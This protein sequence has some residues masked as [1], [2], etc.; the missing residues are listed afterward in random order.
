LLGW[1]AIWKFGVG[2]PI[3]HNWTDPIPYIYNNVFSVEYKDPIQALSKPGSEI[4]I[5]ILLQLFEAKPARGNK[6]F[7]GTSEIIVAKTD[8]TAWQVNYWKFQKLIPTAWRQPT[9]EEGVVLNGP[10]FSIFELVDQPTFNKLVSK[11]KTAVRKL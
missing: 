11:L 5:V 4:P 2:A 8:G 10:G 7:S 9:I 6:H 3:N 1:N